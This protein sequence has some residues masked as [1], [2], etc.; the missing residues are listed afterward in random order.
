VRLPLLAMASFLLAC[1]GSERGPS[2][3]A[4]GGDMSAAGSAPTGG[5]GGEGPS[6]VLACRG[7][8]A[9]LSG[10]DPPF[11]NIV[12]PLVRTT[13]HGLGTVQLVTPSRMEL[14]LDESD[15]RLPVSG[16]A[17]PDFGSVGQTLGVNYTVFN[18]NN[19]EDIAVRLDG[20]NGTLLWFQYDG[21]LAEGVFASILPEL[22]LTLLEDCDDPLDS[23][24]SRNRRLRVGLQSG[25][26]TLALEVGTFAEIE[27]AGSR[28]TVSNFF[29]RDRG[30]AARPCADSRSG[31]L[32]S[33][34]LLRSDLRP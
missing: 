24:Q 15:E 12:L 25:S 22:K 8:V 1:G 5:S 9:T 4:A 14:T 21:E 18:P 7:A 13:F 33:L 26:Q 20:N 10:V 32:L 6:A 3:V 34:Q 2:N 29:S 19:A 27:V 17:V 16:A 23:C 30:I 11:L 31:R 28:Y